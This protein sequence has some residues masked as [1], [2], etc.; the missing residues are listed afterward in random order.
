M[1]LKRQIHGERLV[2]T[3]QELLQGKSFLKVKLVLML[4]QILVLDFFHHQLSLRLHTMQHQKQERKCAIQS[5]SNLMELFYQFFCVSYNPV[6]SPSAGTWDECP[7]RRTGRVV[8][9]LTAAVVAGRSPHRADTQNSGGRGG[10]LGECA[11]PVRAHGLPSL[12]L[13]KTG[14]RA[15][16]VRTRRSSSLQWWRVEANAPYQR[17]DYGDVKHGRAVSTKP[18]Q[19]ARRGRLAPPAVPSMP[20]Y[21]TAVA[22]RPPYRWW[23]LS[24]SVNSD[25][26]NEVFDVKIVN[27]VNK[28]TADIA[29]E[30]ILC[31]NHAEKEKKH[32]A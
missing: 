27:T 7:Y 30:R 19:T 10:A 25:A 3:Q 5:L 15:S 4:R 18:S 31:Y 14:T 13:R 6:R 16:T 21:R 8:S 20:P 28:I 23:Y 2:Q 29:F 17:H 11:L 1:I 9:T 32:A 24:I 22:G 26:L 12:K